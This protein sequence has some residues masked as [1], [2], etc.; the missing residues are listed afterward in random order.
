MSNLKI[1]FNYWII[2]YLNIWIKLLKTFQIFNYSIVRL[3]MRVPQKHR[4][5]GKIEYLTYHRGAILKKEFPV[6]KNSIFVI[7]VVNYS[8]PRQNLE[9]VPLHQAKKK[10][11][12]I[13]WKKNAKEQ[14]TNETLHTGCEFSHS[15]ICELFFFFFSFSHVVLLTH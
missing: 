11:Y 13:Q 3:S 1:G 9:R 5:I 7:S 12:K 10:F 15:A 6:F 14:K 8:R 2:E 4:H